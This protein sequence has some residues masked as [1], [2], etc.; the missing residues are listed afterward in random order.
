L[1]AQ[2]RMQPKGFTLPSCSSHAGWLHWTH[3]ITVRPSLIQ[4][5]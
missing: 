3:T 4:T 5:L 1:T 2:V